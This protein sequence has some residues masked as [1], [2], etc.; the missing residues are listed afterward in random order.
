[1]APDMKKSK[2]ILIVGSSGFVL[3]QVSKNISQCLDIAGANTGNFIF[4][5]AVRKILGDGVRITNIG[6]GEDLKYLDIQ[7]HFDDIDYVVIPAANHLRANADWTGFNSFLAKI[8]KPM[9]V[10]GLGA[11]AASTDDV[12]ET[13]GSLQKCPTVVDMCRIFREKAI[14]VGVRG[15]FS[16]AVCE[17]MGLRNVKA[18]GCPSILLSPNARLGEHLEQS[19]S[20]LKNSSKHPR[21]C[22]VAEAPY[23]IRSDPNKLSTEQKLFD[24]VYQ[25]GGS[26]IQQS[27]GPETIAFSLGQLDLLAETTSKWLSGI[28][29]PRRSV[30]E[31]SS[32]MKAKGRVFYSA[33]DWIEYCK[34][35]DLSIGH[36][37]HGNM[38]TIGADRL[39]VVIS[40]DSRTSEL[41]DFMH[42][43]T[44]KPEV[45]KEEQLTTEL[46][47]NAV[48]FDHEQFDRSRAQI[49]NTWLEVFGSLDVELSSHV[50]GIANQ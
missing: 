7:R 21:M 8:S 22:M 33:L 6:L 20:L 41:V 17:K 46:I 42:I 49:A 26:Y 39:G 37:F 25:E 3:N 40:H 11:Q 29:S 38:A 28:I 1:M 9:L 13:V 12:D 14:F 15:Q 19:I 35:F 10:F 34:A 30:D 36:R 16:K 4:Q 31:V 24:L 32:Y 23:S 18:T 2:H 48:R 50:S 45:F 5:H 27:G 43:P 44:V 47:V